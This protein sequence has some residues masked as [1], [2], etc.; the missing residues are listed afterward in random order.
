MNH[1]SEQD[2]RFHLQPISERYSLDE[3]RQREFTYLQ[4]NRCDLGLPPPG[5]GLRLVIV[6]PALNEEEAVSGV[7]RSLWSQSLP[8]DQFEVIAVDNGS[9]DGTRSVVLNF[10]R[11][12]NLPIHLISEPVKGC[13]RA[14]RTGMDVA[15]HRLAQVSP[16][17]EGIIATIDADDQVGSHWATAVVETITERKTDMIRGPTQLAESPPSQVEL[18]V[19]A[20]CD[21]ENRVNGYVELARLRLEEALLGIRHQGQPLWLPRITGPNIAI[22]RVA[23]VAV[24][25]LD[26][27]PP[28]DQASHLANPLLRTGGIVTLCD[29]LR[30]TLFRSRRCSRR[31]FDQASGFGAG[32]GLGFGDMVYQ[33]TKA[34]EDGTTLNYPNPAWIEAGLRRV[35][36]RLQSEDEEA[37][38]QARKLATRFLE[39]PPDPSALYKYGSSPDEPAQVSIVEA[40]AALLKMKSRAGGMDYR[41]AERFLMA[42]ELLRSQVLSLEGQW[43]E[44]D[45]IIDALLKRMDFSSTNIPRHLRQMV[46]SLKKI[47][48]AENKKW[49]DA[50][51]RTLEEIY[52]QIPTS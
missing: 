32:F 26:P 6:I 39:V 31:N 14:V 30:V 4:N 23:Y 1:M 18:C 35:L 46:A 41:I 33:A 28:G 47:P 45:R 50:A 24:G 52:A 9:T 27:R 51:C 3:L 17:Y 43:I 7:L 37:R 22:S 34:V 25:G 13:L 42:R 29:D 20:L 15:L 10:A 48:N 40:K 11:H 5:S 38:K 8:H 44:S 19:K 49:Y 21:V 2:I 36:V 12:C 16:P